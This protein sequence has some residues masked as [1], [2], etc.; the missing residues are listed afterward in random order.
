MRM[1]CRVDACPARRFASAA[2]RSAQSQHDRYIPTIPVQRQATSKDRREGSAAA[3]APVHAGGVVSRDREASDEGS[4]CQTPHPFF[5]LEPDVRPCSAPK[6]RQASSRISDRGSYSGDALN[7]G[8]S[9]S[10][11]LAKWAAQ[12]VLLVE[13]VT[14]CVDP[15]ARRLIS[16][17]TAHDE[18][19]PALARKR[20]SLSSSRPALLFSCRS[21]HGLNVM[22][23]AAAD[24][25]FS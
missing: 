16:T 8:R 14:V 20:I 2:E 5:C 23:H 10:P 6:A 18:L 22:S 17:N 9:S 21:F 19:T 24:K 15:G 13:S 3:S 1:R 11:P 4:G 25:I 12:V 7:K